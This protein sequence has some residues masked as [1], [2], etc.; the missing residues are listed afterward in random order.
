MF[1]LQSSDKCAT[2]FSSIVVLILIAFI[3][4]SVIP[5]SLYPLFGGIHILLIQKSSPPAYITSSKFLS[6][7]LDSSLIVDGFTNFNMKNKRLRTMIKNL[8]PGYLRIG[9]V[10]ADRLK[11][12]EGD[13]L[14][15]KA[16]VHEQD[17]SDCAYIRQRCVLHSNQYF[18]L[19]DKEWL[20][21]YNLAVDA[22]FTILFDLNS[23]MRNADGSWNHKNAE[24]MIKFSNGNQMNVI[25]QLG[26]EPNSY[27]YIFNYT[28][29]P[30]QLVKDF[31]TL[32]NIL[33]K[34][35]MYRNKLLVG[36]DI[37][38][39]APENSE[40]MTYLKDFLDNSGAEVVDAIT[41]H[42]YYFNGR[43]ATKDDFLDPVTY[44]T[45]TAQINLMKGIIRYYQIKSKSLWLSE[46]SDA[47]S[48]GAPGYS[49]RYIGTFIWLDK[50][51]IAAK[52]G[53]DIV[54]RQTLFKGY[55]AL[56]NTNY[57]PTPNYWISVLY[58]TFV[59]PEVV[60]CVSASSDKVRIYC[61]C[62]N[63]NYKTSSITLFGFNLKGTD[64]II[65]L[66]GLKDPRDSLSTIY[67]YILSPYVSLYSKNV[68][69][70]GELLA[71]SPDG[72]L[73]YFKPIIID[74][75]MHVIIP[76]HSSAFF[77]IPTEIVACQ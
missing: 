32:R 75:E 5:I 51:G 64:T 8:G 15:V 72:E 34:Y 39:P 66:E 20:G 43:T 58:K 3:I 71:L 74:N 53:L 36:P 27:R 77:I 1:S 21:L 76:A 24:E 47:F 40:S 63:K 50:L 60:R 18:T 35:P 65:R 70:N 2:R 41:F 19:S 52:L 68:Y 22:G 16:D 25:W 61:H 59:G 48:G 54:V 33:D 28:V 10:M 23:L 55:Y 13:I 30:M 17:G 31:A 46:T 44:N 12:I 7:A 26:N 37:T 56:I 62:T 6:V 9:G 4:I 73:P 38:N 14:S 29:T 45:L 49:N 11:F 69:L 42:Q 57:E 67:S